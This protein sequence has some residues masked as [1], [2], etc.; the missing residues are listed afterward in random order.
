MGFEN[1]KPLIKDLEVNW[2]DSS[3]PNADDSH[4]F[5]VN[6]D[7]KV[8]ALASPRVG[9]DGSGRTPKASAFV[10]HSQQSGLQVNLDGSEGQNFIIFIQLHIED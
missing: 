1:N 9:A 3:S 10:D 6:D 4:Q 8:P 5:D 2:A 7:S